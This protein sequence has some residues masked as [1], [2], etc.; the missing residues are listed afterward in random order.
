MPL[1]VTFKS[2]ISA[3]HFADQVPGTSKTV[4][5][6]LAVS[7]WEVPVVNT[8]QTEDTSLQGFKE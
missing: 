3:V 5:S 4:K 2:D 8:S 6:K 7:G 1:L